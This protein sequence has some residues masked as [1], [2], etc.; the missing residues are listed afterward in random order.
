MS[1]VDPDFPELL[2]YLTCSDDV[3]E[4]YHFDAMTLST[5]TN[6]T[7]CKSSNEDAPLDVISVGHILQCNVIDY[8]GMEI[9]P[10][11]FGSHEVTFISYLAVRIASDWTRKS[12]YALMDGA[13]LR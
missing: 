10:R 12:T 5:T 13:S 8:P 4:L 9:C 2:N 11:S 6:G 3:D 1:S 7:F